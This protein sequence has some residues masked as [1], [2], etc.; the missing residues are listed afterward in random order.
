[1]TMTNNQYPVFKSIGEAIETFNHATE[2]GDHELAQAAYEYF[3]RHVPAEDARGAMEEA[4]SER[5]YERNLLSWAWSLVNCY[6]L[7]DD[8]GIRAAFSAL[9]AYMIK[10]APPELRQRLMRA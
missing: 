2:H 5:S 6:Q 7:S 4:V 8:P 3:W 1:M 10:N 9:N